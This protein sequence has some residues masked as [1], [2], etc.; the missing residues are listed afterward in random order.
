MINIILQRFKEQRRGVFIYLGSLVAFGFVMI[1]LFPTIKKMDIMSLIESYPKEIANFFSNSGMQSY[2]TFEGYISME[3]LSFF[4]ILIIM[5]YV[6][7]TAGTA[8]AGQREKRTLDFN[9]SQ[10][11][12]RTKIVLAESLVNLLNSAM[13]VL[14]TALSLLVFTKI[15]NIDQSLSGIIA[16]FVVATG[17]VWAHLGLGMLLSSFLKSKSNVAFLVVGISLAS[18]IML[19][20]TRIIEKLKFLEDFSIYRLYNPESLLRDGTINLNHIVIL[21]SIMTIGVASSIIIFNKK[22]A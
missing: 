7:N 21:L 15:Y 13:I 4:F 14:G 12:S 22:D 20:L 11:I 8:I 16:F 5:F 10:P 17:F 3:Y 6:G 1:S 2:G 19:S 9:L 18:Y